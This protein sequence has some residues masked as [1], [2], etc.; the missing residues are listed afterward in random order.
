LLESINAA[1][2]VATSLSRRVWEIRAPPQSGGATA[3]PLQKKRS[4]SLQFPM[5]SSCSKK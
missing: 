4:Q 3:L 1:T 2:A 5:T